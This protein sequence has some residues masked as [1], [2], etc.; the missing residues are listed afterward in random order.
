M[1]FIKKLFKRVVNRETVMYLIFGVLT[2]LVNWVV[3]VPFDKL[4]GGEAK[5]VTTEGF[6]GAIDTFL[7]K[8]TAGIIAWVAAVAFAYVTNRFFVFEE[9]AH[10]AK[11]VVMECGKFVGA[12]V[13]TGVIEILGT[14]ALVVMGLTAK[15]FGLDIAK[16]IVS[17]IIIVLNYVFSKLFVFKNMDSEKKRSTEKGE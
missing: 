3:Y 16:L 12:R 17:V 13:F 15:I 1:E 7:S 10:G 6:Q 2:T 4:L 14:P 9:R 11:N 8:G 5:T